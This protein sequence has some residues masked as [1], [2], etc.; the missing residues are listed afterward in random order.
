[1]NKLRRIGEK[2]RDGVHRKEDI[3]TRE[4]MEAP[5]KVLIKV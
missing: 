3:A 2:E 5:S 4:D 1:V